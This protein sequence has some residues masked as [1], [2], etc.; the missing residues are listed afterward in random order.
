MKNIKSSEDF[1]VDSI[2]N[3]LSKYLITN[4]MEN[5][6]SL[7]EKILEIIS[8]LELKLKFHIIQKEV[9]YHSSHLT[10]ESINYMVLPFWPLVKIISIRDESSNS[11]EGYEIL[12]NKL[13]LLHTSP[14]SVVISYE[15]GYDWANL[16]SPMKVLI[17]VMEFY[18]RQYMEIGYFNTSEEIKNILVELTNIYGKGEW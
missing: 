7:N 18:L 9:I 4:F 13:K 1:I 14:C 11:I 10:D 15:T 5:E 17:Y 16:I 2:K 8:L 12:N 3:N 6:W